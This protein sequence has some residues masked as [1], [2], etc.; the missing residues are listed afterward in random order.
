VQQRRQ[1]NPNNRSSQ[2][3]SPIHPP[4][5]PSTSISASIRS[6]KCRAETEEAKGLHNTFRCFLK[7]Q[8]VEN[9]YTSRN[10]LPTNQYPN[11]PVRTPKEWHRQC[12][13]LYPNGVACKFV[14][15][16]KLL[17]VR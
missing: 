13:N 14:V 11:H 8:P 4:Q 6:P 7:V 3:Q 12:H 5:V 9:L 16:T 2:W 10:T 17:N 1:K 15:G